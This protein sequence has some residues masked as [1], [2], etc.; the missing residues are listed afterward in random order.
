MIERLNQHIDNLEN[1]IRNSIPESEFK[2]K[3]TTFHITD[4]GSGQ[5]ANVIV[6]ILKSYNH[7][8]KNINS[9]VSGVTNDII[10]LWY[11][12]QTIGCL[13]KYDFAEKFKE[14]ISDWVI[15][16]PS[17]KESNDNYETLKSLFKIANK[18]VLYMMSGK[19]IFDKTNKYTDAKLKT[20]LNNYATNI[21][22]CNPTIYGGTASNKNGIPLS[23]TLFQTDKSTSKIKV[24]DTILNTYFEYN[25]IDDI[26]IYGNDK[27]FFKIKNKVINYCKESGSLSDIIN[28]KSGRLMINLPKQRGHGS[29]VDYYTPETLSFYSNDS[30]KN[31]GIITTKRDGYYSIDGFNETNVGNNILDYLTNVP[32]SRF[33]LSIFKYDISVLKTTFNAIP[34]FDFNKKVTNDVIMKKIGLNKTELKWI[35]KKMKKYM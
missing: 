10:T 23:F 8:D 9:R 15:T 21:T 1:W 6:D 19:S 2:S 31:Y 5:I 7:S 26:T 22:I 24:N 28:T 13:G 33:G 35:E 20:M 30:N 3:T 14:Y 12:K 32:L 27:T 25:S 18:G 11:F 34:L 17:I 29:S 16:L 4:L